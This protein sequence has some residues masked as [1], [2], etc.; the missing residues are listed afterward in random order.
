M[1]ARNKNT[2]DQAFVEVFYTCRSSLLFDRLH[3]L[4]N[5]PSG[6]TNNIGPTQCSDAEKWQRHVIYIDV[7]QFE[8]AHPNTMSTNAMALEHGQCADYVSLLPPTCETEWPNIPRDDSPVEGVG[9]EA[10]DG[11][12]EAPLF[13]VAVLVSHPRHVVCPAD[14]TVVVRVVWHLFLAHT[15]RRQRNL[16]GEQHLK[17]KQTCTNIG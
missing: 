3:F 7:K 13:P 12:H 5:W 16:E 9:E 2:A 4:L 11:T 17:Q 8:Q 6:D 15:L 1:F 14:R 10:A